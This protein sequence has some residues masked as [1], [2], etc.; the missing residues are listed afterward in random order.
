MIVGYFW[1]PHEFGPPHDL[2]PILMIPIDPIGLK[3]HNQDILYQDY[4]QSSAIQ[5]TTFK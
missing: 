1:G 5:F 2:V 4:S 3:M